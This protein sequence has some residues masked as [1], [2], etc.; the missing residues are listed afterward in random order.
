MLESLG[1]KGNLD[2]SVNSGVRLGIYSL[3]DLLARGFSALWACFLTV[4]G[5]CDSAYCIREKWRL[6]ELRHV[7]TGV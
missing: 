1:F 6:N 7:A 4:N 3:C 2:E 5:D